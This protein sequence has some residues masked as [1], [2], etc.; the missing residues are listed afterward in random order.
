MNLVLLAL[1]ACSLAACTVSTGVDSAVPEPTAVSEI[2]KTESTLEDGRDLREG[3]SAARSITPAE[4]AA[5]ERL[6]HT[7]EIERLQKSE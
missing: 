1:V 4:R 3:E 7:A 2:A 6:A 5:A